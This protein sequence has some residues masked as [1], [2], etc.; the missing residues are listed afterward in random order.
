MKLTVFQA[1]KGDCLLLESKDDKRVLIDGGMRAAYKEH[2][3][4]ALG[5]LEQKGK[6]L[7]LVYVSHIDRDH[8]SGVLQLMDDLVAWRVFDFQQKSGNTRA[9][10]P[11]ATRPPRVRDLWHNPFHEAVSKNTGP[12]EDMLATHAALLQERRASWALEQAPLQRELATS[13]AEGIELSRRVRP[14]QLD[15]AVNRHFDGKLALVRA[16]GQPIAIGTLTMSVI[17]PFREDLEALR[18]EWNTWLRANK[19]QLADLQRRLDRDT[20]R[21]R[22]SE[23]EQLRT[24]LTLASDEIGDRKEVTVPNLASLML[25]VEEDGKSILL[26]GDGHHADILKGLAHAGKLSTHGGIH[27]DVLKVQHH[28]S[29]HNLDLPF[30]RKVTANHYIFCGNGEH[31]NPDTRVIR[32]IL[33]SRLGAQAKRSP[34]PEATRPFEFHF[35]SSSKATEGADP[36]AHMRLVERQA[37][38]AA[39]SSSGQLTVNFIETASSFE[40]KVA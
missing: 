9:K 12:I 5:E 15:I 1:G 37:R 38:N 11:K 27:V 32:A 36:R 4:P 29:E 30:A 14:E 40:L 24:A 2:V 22:T 6:A 25:L 26:T 17:G 33:D 28:G 10:Q 13:I 19:K 3:A 34:N 16:D 21:L 7:D 18:A 8:I 20:D 39:A 23:F 35:N 31:E